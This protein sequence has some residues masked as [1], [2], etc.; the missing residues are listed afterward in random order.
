MIDCSS[1]SYQRVGKEKVKEK[2]EI[3]DIGKKPKDIMEVKEE[4]NLKAGFG[5]MS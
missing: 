5:W 4:R 1:S 3:G 2:R